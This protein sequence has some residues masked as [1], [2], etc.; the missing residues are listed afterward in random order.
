MQ[1]SLRALRNVIFLFLLWIIAFQT[2]QFTRFNTIESN[3][4]ILQKQSGMMR[5]RDKENM[6]MF[7]LKEQHRIIKAVGKQQEEE[8]TEVKPVNPKLSIHASANIGDDDDRSSSSRDC[9]DDDNKNNM[10]DDVN[11][12]HGQQK[13]SCKCVNCEEDVLCG[14]L[15]NGTQVT[16]DIEG[17]NDI[18]KKE[19][20]VVVSHCRTDL[21]FFPDFTAGFNIASIHVISKCGHPVRGAPLDATIEVLPNVGRCDHSYAHYITNVLDKKVQL[22]SQ[23]N[24][25]E[26]AIVAFLKDNAGGRNL[27]Q[28]GR[29]NSFHDMVQVASSSVGF[30]CGIVPGPWTRNAP[31]YLMSAY[32][33]LETLRKFAI[34]DYTSRNKYDSDSVPFESALANWDLFYKNL[35]AGSSLE[36]ELVQVC[37]GG[38]FAVSVKNIKKRKM[39]VWKAAEQSLSRGDNIQEGHYMERTWAMLLATPL[40]QYQVEAIKRYSEYTFRPGYGEGYKSEA[41]LGGLARWIKRCN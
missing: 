20:H 38:V 11:P 37:Y 33:E 35:G 21:D 28:P 41:F 30:S 8:G 15:W 36:P 4:R 19:I 16:G 10:N 25:G 3:G 40:E 32:F 34:V 12:H 1:V 29:W 18:Y 7:V 39:G 26:D 13:E 31:K 24:N 5:L 2:W 27:H 14:K 6:Y 22:G 23:D 17:N 9:A